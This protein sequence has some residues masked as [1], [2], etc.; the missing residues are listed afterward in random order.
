LPEGRTVADLTRD[1]VTRAFRDAGYR[2]VGSDDPAPAQPITVRIDQFWAWMTPGF[3]TLTL[4]HEARVNVRGPVTPFQD[5][6][7]L[8]AYASQKGQVAASDA[9]TE[10]VNK[11]LE[12]LTA[13]IRAELRP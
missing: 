2:V 4:E 11:G 12:D 13:K 9:W 10:I 5:G 7:A 6:K 3:W 1:A 8:R